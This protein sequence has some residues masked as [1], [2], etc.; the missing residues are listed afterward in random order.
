MTSPAI[1]A[2][3][4]PSPEASSARSRPTDAAEKP[5]RV[6]AVW[7]RLS[8]ADLQRIKRELDAGRPES[9]PGMPKS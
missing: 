4:A 7:S 3:E 6:D 8:R 9:W 1:R 5:E 2:R